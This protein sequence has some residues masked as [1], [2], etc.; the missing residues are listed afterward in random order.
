MLNPGRNS[1]PN[2]RLI[3]TVQ[4]AFGPLLLAAVML[5]V[6]NCGRAAVSATNSGPGV[7]FVATNGNDQWTGSRASPNL[8]KSDGPFATVPRALQAARDYR[9][10]AAGTSNAPAGIFLRGGLYTLTEP[11]VLK[12]EDSNLVLAGYGNETPVL[13]GGRRITGWQPVV[14][15]GK[16]LWAAELPEVRDGKWS[17]HELWVN[18]QRALLARYP[19]QGYLRVA[20]VPDK[21]ADVFKSVRRFKYKSGDLRVTSTLTNA[22][23]SVMN[24]WMDSHLPISS[25]D[26]VNQLINSTKRTNVGLKPG[27]PYYLEGAIDFLNEPGEWCLDSSTGV[28]Y[29]FP[30]SGETLKNVDAIAPALT[31]VLRMEGRPEAGEVVDR[32]RL[33][34]LTFSHNEWYFPAS[35][36]G[37]KTV[38]GAGPVPAP[39][40]QMGGVGQGS[41][42]LPATVWGQGVVRCLI[43]ECAITHVG[44]YA[45]EL[46]AGCESNLVSRCEFG[47]LGAGGIKLGGK[48][49]PKNAVEVTHD[50]EI[51][52]CSVHDGG[53]VF[54]S[55]EAILLFQT[56][57]NRL[58][59]NLV[60]N[61]SHCGICVGWTWGYGPALASNNVVAF[62][63]IHHLGARTDGDGPILSDLGAIYTLGKQP[64]T[65]L[66]NNLIHDIAGL[67]YGGWGIYF[68]E[69]SSGILAESNIVYRTTHGGFYQHFGATN[70][71]LNNIFAF[72]RDVQIQR[73]LNENHLSF[74]FMFNIVYFDSGTLIAGNWPAHQFR[75]DQNVY[76]DARPGAKP[77]GII[78]QNATL[79]QWQAMG[80]DEHSLFADP[81][82]IAPRQ[83]D[84]H[85]WSSSPA[86]KMGFHPIDVSTAGIRPH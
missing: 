46:E 17:F 38:S 43:R 15:Q 86:L 42:E 75:M 34:H 59:H 23:V 40:L 36:K 85:F 44:T 31:Q 35:R 37:A 8:Q 2:D 55:S 9:K 41:Y 83:Y 4:N 79:Q 22:E 51:S 60:Y 71:V 53:Q 16:S 76:F 25:V 80:N 21:T 29:Y 63:H 78:F 3:G 48:V 73:G 28:L 77:G 18:N 66:L 14:V 64:G 49:I 39:D 74:V 45:L 69:G 65:K 84:F 26:E 1:F 72:G 57:N 11:L 13:S 68:D 20:E 6:P 33:R 58:L 67:D 7:F 56:P 19:R 82:F 12:P 24:L 5:L 70:G 47:D 50:N 52:D 81:L 32:V 61:F 62:N 27:N 54:H 10:Q 30:R